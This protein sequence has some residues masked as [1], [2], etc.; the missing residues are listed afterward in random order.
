MVRQV[1]RAVL[2]FIVCCC[3]C[4]GLFVIY[5]CVLLIL[6]FYCV[7]AEHCIVS[8]DPFK[9]TASFFGTSAN[10][11]KPEQTPQKTASDQV[12]RCLQTEG[13]LKLN[14]NENYHTTTLNLEVD[15]SD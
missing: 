10:S 8:L 4:W 1:G 2:V 11:A 9:H 12:L 6:L 3:G 14:K 5:W 15:L 7:F 13:S